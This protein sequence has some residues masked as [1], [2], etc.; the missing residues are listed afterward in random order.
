MATQGYP[1]ADSGFQAFLLSGPAS[2]GG[3]SAG[4]ARLE[5]SETAAATSPSGT[6][7]PVGAEAACRGKNLEFSGDFGS[8]GPKQL[9]DV[10]QKGT[11]MKTLLSILSLA[12]GLAI[13]QAQNFTVSL[14]P[15]QEANPV[16]GRTGSGIG[17]LTLT[18]TTLTLDNGERDLPSAE[19]HHD[20]RWR[21]RRHHRRICQPGAP[22]ERRLHGGAAI[23]RPGERSMVCRRSHFDFSRRGN[24]RTNSARAGTFDPGAG[25][26]GT[27][28]AADLEIATPWGVISLVNP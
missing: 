13:A 25:R 17:N 19:Y 7:N 24:P 3:V 5:H 23:V 8:L 18:G 20:F 11:L 22:A 16:G 12:S 6:G 14:D 1:R 21:P 27:G 26:P 10:T 28:R 9:S 2:N 15:T 4:P